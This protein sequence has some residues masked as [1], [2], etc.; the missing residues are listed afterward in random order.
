MGVTVIEKKLVSTLK[1]FQLAVLK[2]EGWGASRLGVDSVAVSFG[3]SAIHL[4]RL[5]SFLMDSFKVNSFTF[6]EL[7]VLK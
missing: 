6:H 7:C 1:S 4:S 3:K 5:A 2:G